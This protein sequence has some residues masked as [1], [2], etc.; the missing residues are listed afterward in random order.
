MTVEVLIEGLFVLLE[1]FRLA[2]DIVH[3]ARYFFF[4]VLVEDL[5]VFY[6][7]LLPTL[8]LSHIIF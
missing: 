2:L 4:L 7:R 3:N 8:E 6:P 5:L 1:L